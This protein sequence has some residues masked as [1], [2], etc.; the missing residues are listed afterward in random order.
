MSWALRLCTAEGQEQ[1]DKMN[2]NFLM[3]ALSTLGYLPSAHLLI[4]SVT[5]VQSL[6]PRTRMVHWRIANIQSLKSDSLEVK[7]CVKLGETKIES[8]TGAL[9]LHCSGSVLVTPQPQLS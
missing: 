1:N 9:Q 8:T 6:K 5:C 7:S 4:P 3:L 2:V